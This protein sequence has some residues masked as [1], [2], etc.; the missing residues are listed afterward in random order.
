MEKRSEDWL[1]GAEW[2][3]CLALGVAEANDDGAVWVRNNLVE[4]LKAAWYREM[5]AARERG[6]RDTA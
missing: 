6:H 5:G 1:A 2:G 3:F 4:K